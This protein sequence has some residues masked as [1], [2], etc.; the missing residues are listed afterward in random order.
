MPTWF[1]GTSPNGDLQQAIT[2]AVNKGTPAV[3][4]HPDELITWT[5]EKISGKRGGL[6]GGNEVSVT[7]A[8]EID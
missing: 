3:P 1:T 6:A 4:A 5:V 7:I 2:D 8:V